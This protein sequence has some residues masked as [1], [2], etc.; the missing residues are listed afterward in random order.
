[1]TDH[2]HPIANVWERIDGIGI[3]ILIT[4]DHGTPRARPMG[5]YV[6][7]EDNAIY[8]FTNEGT[9]KEGEAARHPE[10]SLMFQGAGESYVAIN[11]TARIVNDRDKIRE[12]WSTTAKAWWNG[13]DDP[14]I[15]LM[16]VTPYEAEIWDSP[17]RIVSYVAM[18]AAV[19]T[20]GKPAV[21]ENFKVKM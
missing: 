21:G 15:R 11:G 5:A 18:I 13:P 4:D 20:G 1:M 3:C 14:N 19:V 8:L 9:E 17:G 12:L 16:R 2:D 7:Q 10:V 6:R